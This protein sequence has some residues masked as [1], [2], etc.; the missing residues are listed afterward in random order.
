MSKLQTPTPAQIARAT[1]YRLLG[2]T[3]CESCQFFYGEARDI[4]VP[5]KTK[6]RYQR[7]VS[8]E[9]YYVH[10]ALEQN[11]KLIK[12]YHP[13][14]YSFDIKGDRYPNITDSMKQRCAHYLERA[15]P[16]PM[17]S[18]LDRASGV[19]GLTAKAERAIERHRKKR[20][21]RFRAADE[22][23][24]DRQDGEVEAAGP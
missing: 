13:L 3:S 10:C 19:F 5:S 21:N 14:T 16:L 23:S 11:P 20:R 9:D 15:A 1:K 8:Y 12:D 2:E 18:E 4:E 6:E 22:R 17:L 24:A 7:T